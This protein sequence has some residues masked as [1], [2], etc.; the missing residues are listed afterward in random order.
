[1]K[2]SPNDEAISEQFYA[3]PTYAADLLAEVRRN[4]DL[5]E[6]AVLMRQLIMVVGLDNWWSAADAKHRLPPL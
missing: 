5:A 2:D 4:G 1:M 6:L 3:E